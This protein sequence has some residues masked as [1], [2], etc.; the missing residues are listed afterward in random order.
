ML[1]L[2]QK[3]Y[4]VVKKTVSWQ[5]ARDVFESRGEQYK[6]AILDENIARDDMAG[7]VPS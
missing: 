2:A 5:E 1:E 7:S 3:N 4:D 6:V